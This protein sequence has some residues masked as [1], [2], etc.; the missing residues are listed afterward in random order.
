MKSFKKL[1]LLGLLAALP[2]L[3]QTNS[4]LQR[5][6][7]TSVINNGNVCWEA[8]AGA[9]PDVCLVRS[10]AGVL[11]VTQGDAVT[12]ATIAL[13]SP[14]I[15]VANEGATGTTVN[16]LAKFTGAPSTAIIAGTGDNKNGA[17]VGVVVGG[18]GT[19]GS[20]QITLV[21]TA[22]CAFDATAVTAGDFVTVSSTVGGKCHDFGSSIPTDGS[23]IIG[24]ALATGNASTTQN[25]F[26]TPGLANAD[27][28]VVAA[29]KTATINNSITFAGTDATTMTF[30][31]TSATIARTDV[32]QTFTGHNVFEGIT[33]TGATGTGNMVFATTPTL[34]TPVI[35][36]ATG[37]SLA[38]SGTASLTLGTSGS[39]VGQ[40]ILNN[41]TSGTITL[42]PATG[43]L[44]TTTFTLPP[45]SG[46]LAPILSCGSTGSGNQTCSPTAATAKAQIYNGESTLSGSAATITFPNAFTSTTT[47]FCVA[48]DVTT[49]ANPVQMIPASAS[50]ATITN[51][52]GAT[53][54]IQW[55]CIGN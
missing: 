7:N 12:G 9:G 35:G 40:V 38:L 6:S 34:T 52:T 14:T 5:L 11:S 43:A 42:Q 33:P 15:S 53:D 44:S 8:T 22:A 1:L 23:Q 54:V 46:N 21:G 28:V 51:T 2:V 31:S 3:A 27:S 24:R 39:L 13:G 16:K 19:T 20:A 18:A 25:I 17:V 32:A 41:A 36:A 49:R 4:G 29:G 45:I 37:T 26:I 50:T 10:S 47:Y 30:P 55:V 48:N